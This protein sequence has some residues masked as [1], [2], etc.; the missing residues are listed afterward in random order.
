MF[1]SFDPEKL[2]YDNKLIFILMTQDH[3]QNKWLI[4]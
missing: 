1:I 3:E 4:F 2:V